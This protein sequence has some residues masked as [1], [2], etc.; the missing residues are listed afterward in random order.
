MFKNKYLKYKKKYI[1][2]KNNPL[3]GGTQK[4][5]YRSIHQ[6]KRQILQDFLNLP[7]EEK[8]NPDVVL[9][10]YYDN[11]SI[12]NHVPIELYDNKEFMK[13]V[14]ALNGQ[15]LYLASEIL[16]RDTE[17]IKIAIMKDGKA[18]QHVPEDLKTLEIVSLAIQNDYNAYK[19]VPDHM[20]NDPDMV[21]NALNISPS[22]MMHLTDEMKN[23]IDIVLHAF[24]QEKRTIGYASPAFQE[25]YKLATGR[26]P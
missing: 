14:L 7:D 9:E 15:F 1:D 18:L 8:K 21:K 16:K 17:I 19:F 6:K 11:P 3:K 10:A 13:K 4:N 25:F 2:L 12:I 5:D 22:V 24:K 23:N 26:N 20:K